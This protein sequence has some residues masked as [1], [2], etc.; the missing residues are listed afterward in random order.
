VILAVLPV[1]TA[2]AARI[3][4]WATPEPPLPV[5]P[6][7]TETIRL[8][9]TSPFRVRW[10][11]VAGLPP[12]QVVAQAEVPAA[13][14]PRPRPEAVEPLPARPPSEVT[15]KR[16]LRVNNICSRHGMV[17]QITRGGKSWRCRR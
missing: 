6:V 7:R 4:V 11:P 5:R 3:A 16:V 12:A 8:I 9:D 10:E 13:P 2:I 14:M 1:V 15:R 17:K